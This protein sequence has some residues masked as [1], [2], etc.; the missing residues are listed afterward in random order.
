MRL[1]TY[2]YTVVRDGSAT[3]VDVSEIQ[4][5]IAFDDE[6]TDDDPKASR[7][8]DF[9]DFYVYSEG[10]SCRGLHVPRHGDGRW[11]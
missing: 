7:Q 3:P 8:S 11:R 4:Q 2:S 10:C 1:L 6:A 5:W 9:S